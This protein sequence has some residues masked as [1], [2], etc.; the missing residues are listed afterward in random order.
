MKIQ[1]FDIDNWK[2]IGATLARNKTRTFLTGFGIFW[3]VFMLACL[4]GG[5]RGAEDLLRRNFE[6]FASN[7]AILAPTKTTMPYQGHAK[8]RKWQL[9]L[10]DLQRIRQVFPELETVTTLA[11][12][13][14]NSFRN[15]KYSYSG[16]V[17]GVQETFTDVM[18]P[19]ID[20]GRFINTADNQQQRKVAVIGK[21]VANELFPGIDS[22]VG[23]DVQINGIVYTIIGVAYQSNE[24]QMTGDRIDNVIIIPLSTCQKAFNM[25]TKI[26]NIMIV[27]THNTKISK[28]E[29]RLRHLLYSRHMIAPADDS[30][31][32]YMD[33]SA[34][35]ANVD[36]LF[37][38]ISF[39][40]FF[41]GI[42][43][44]IAGIIGIGN[45]MWV[46]VKERTQEFGIRRAIGAKPSDLTVQ[47]LSE[48]VTLTAVAGLTG[49]TFA[50]ISLGIA[51]AT[52]ADAVSTPRFQM[53]LGQAG[54]IFG[55]FIILG[56]LAGLIPAIK[57]MKIK[58]IEALNDK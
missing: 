43:T 8:G 53:T 57:A 23:H 54:I 13:S 29:P 39:L 51:A 50:C 32:F 58:P 9:D 49:I 19:T 7:S 1:F 36:T 55:I 18:L 45:I 34:M 21:K 2:E 20:S 27:A 4:M 52:T 5:A 24:V 44:L 42:S 16:Q 3:G 17:W 47:I 22:P 12:R 46:I 38:G 25:G 15:G 14:F 56:T 48:G 41:I 35:F 28:I 26:D 31:M 40:A 37:I 33:I 30:A 6:G 11:S 10:T